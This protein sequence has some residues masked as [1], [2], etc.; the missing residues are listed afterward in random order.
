[1]TFLPARKEGFDGIGDD[2][3]L[4]RPELPFGLETPPANGEVFKPRGDA[5]TPVDA[6][7]IPSEG[8]DPSAPIE[9]ADP[10]SDGAGP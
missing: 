1:M 4:I 6:A 10:P 8:G 7:K 5:M 9:G 3:G 2:G